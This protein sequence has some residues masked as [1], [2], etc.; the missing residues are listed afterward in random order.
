MQNG[1]KVQNFPTILL[2]S[3][4]LK[5]QVSTMI[6]GVDELNA[7]EGYRGTSF[8]SVFL[9]SASEA[10]LKKINEMYI[11]EQLQAGF[12]EMIDEYAHFNTSARNSIM[13]RMT[14]DYMVIGI[15]SQTESYKYKSEIISDEQSFYKDERTEIGNLCNQVLDGSMDKGSFYDEIKGY[16][17]HY[18]EDRYEFRNQPET[19]KSIN[20]GSNFNS[21]S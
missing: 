17:N 13:E 6:A 20:I 18:Y 19:V 14:P 4:A 7:Q 15:G 3:Q 11:P 16:L 21:Y 9:L 5:E 12:S 8:E 1:R 2:L 10:G